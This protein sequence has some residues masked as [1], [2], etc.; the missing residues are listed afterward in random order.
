MDWEVEEL[1]DNRMVVLKK[2]FS[3]NY[4]LLDERVVFR[5]E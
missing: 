5:K 4:D 2:T 3:V 1:T